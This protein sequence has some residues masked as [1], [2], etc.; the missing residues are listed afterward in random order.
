M[1][2]IRTLLQ[3][4]VLMVLIGKT[5][6]RTVFWDVMPYRCLCI[7]RRGYPDWGISLAFSSVV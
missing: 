7:L 4:T 1:E 3:K 6:K 2:Q 5:M